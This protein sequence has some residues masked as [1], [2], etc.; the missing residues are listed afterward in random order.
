M[1]KRKLAADASSPP[2]ETKPPP[3]SKPDTRCKTAKTSEL[4]RSKGVAPAAAAVEDSPPDP[5]L[6]RARD[7]E[8]RPQ[9]WERIRRESRVAGLSRRDS[10]AR[11]TTEVELLFPAEPDPVEDPEPPTETTKPRGF[12]LSESEPQ[13]SGVT[14]LGD[15]P[16]DWPQLPANASL[17]SEVQWVT[18]NRLRV[19]DGNRV[20]LTRSL[21]PAPS[22]SALSWLETA[23]LFPSKF[24][25]VAVKVT[26]NQED[27]REHVRR[28]KLA[29]Q[30]I[31]ELLAEMVEAD[32]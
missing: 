10:Y 28:E 32:D 25:D 11:A 13:S 8:T 1:A 16:D 19:R 27:E 23:I 24:A 2:P 22:H 30:E 3:K 29:I 20:D 31:R 5:P 9:T 4:K 7:G 21:G 17:A 14:G 26:A 6:S 18:A 12:G 15:I